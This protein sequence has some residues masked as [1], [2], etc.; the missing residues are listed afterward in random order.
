MP[1]Q[2][3]HPPAPVSG[4]APATV[5]HLLCHCQVRGFGLLCSSPF[6]PKKPWPDDRVDR[7]LSTASATVPRPWWGRYNRGRL[8]CGQRPTGTGTGIASSSLCALATACDQSWASG[9]C[10][11][12]WL[13]PAQAVKVSHFSE[14]AAMNVAGAEHHLSPPHINVFLFLQSLRR[15]PSHA[16]GARQRLPM[17]LRAE[18]FQD[19]PPCML[20]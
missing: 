16:A 17:T 10:G 7:S 4:D 20:N 6:R 5:I 14:A 18:N 12:S 15:S 3:P 8:A 11:R 19:L 13:L 9:T 2:P 1:G